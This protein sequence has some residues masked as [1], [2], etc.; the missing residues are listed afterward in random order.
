MAPSGELDETEFCEER[1]RGRTVACG[2]LFWFV[3]D[4]W[5]FDAA[6]RG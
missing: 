2:A 5:V 1:T 3:V 6:E 4:D